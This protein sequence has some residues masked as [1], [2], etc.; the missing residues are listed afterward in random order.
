MG[1]I[2]RF[3]YNYLIKNTESSLSGVMFYAVIWIHI[4]KGIEAWI[5]PVYVGIIR[6][7]I[8]LLLINFFLIKK[9][10]LIK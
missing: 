8:I 3:I 1:I 2:F 6:T 5:A 9:N 7:I 4:I 10:S